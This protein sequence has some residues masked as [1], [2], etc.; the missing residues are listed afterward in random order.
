MIRNSFFSPGSKGPSAWR[1]ARDVATVN[2]ED[3]RVAVMNGNVSA[4]KKFLDKG[5]L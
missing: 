3:F 4:V 1:G 2:L 5:E